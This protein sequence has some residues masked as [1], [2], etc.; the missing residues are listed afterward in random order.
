MIKSARLPLVALAVGVLGVAGCGGDNDNGGG[1]GPKGGGA[2]GGEDSDRGG[3]AGERGGG[4][5]K[6]RG[7]AAKSGA[8][9][10]TVKLAETDFKTPPADPK[11]GKAGTVTFAISNDGQTTHALEVEGPGE[12]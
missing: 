3:G 8:A 10:G 5:A 1:G 4:E 2:G 12:E 7:G 11:A 6:T 9:A